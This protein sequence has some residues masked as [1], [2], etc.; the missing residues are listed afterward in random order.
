MRNENNKL[1]LEKTLEEI[2]LEFKQEK[3]S[4]KSVQKRVKENIELVNYLRQNLYDEKIRA[5]YSIFNTNIKELYEQY[6]ESKFFEEA[7][8]ELK[9]EYN[10]EYINKYINSAKDL[11]N[12]FR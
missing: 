6:L 3:S 5:I 4:S 11:I 7:I 12:Y 8:V 2:I 1:I 10:A 9:K